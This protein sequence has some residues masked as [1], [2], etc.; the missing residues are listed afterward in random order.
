MPSS[1]DKLETMTEKTLGE[2]HG[3]YLKTY[4]SDVFE[5]FRKTCLEHYQMDPAHFYT[6]PGLSWKAA[7]KHTGVHLELLR[8]IDMLLMF[9]QG[10]RSGI[11]QVVNR[12]A[13]ANNKYMSDYNPDKA[14]T[15]LQYLDANNLYDWVMDEAVDARL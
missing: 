9:E 8:D 14:S 6:A 4:L 3:T 2:Y 10:I 1:L 5:T 13:K 15:F 11:T 7:L 12:Y